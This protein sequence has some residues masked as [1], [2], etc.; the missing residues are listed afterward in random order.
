MTTAPETGSGT[1]RP[2]VLAVAAGVLAGLVVW[3]LLVPLGGMELRANVGGS[4]QEV[5]VFAVVLASLLGCLVGW[6]A[7]AVLERRVARPRRTWLLLATALVV[8]SFLS[9]VFQAAD[10][11]SVVGLSLMHVAVA[12]AAVPLFARTL[13]EG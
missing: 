2:R 3:V 11:S 9:P 8:L 7:V 1:V 13:P 6:A 12:L 4:E 10:T 5:P